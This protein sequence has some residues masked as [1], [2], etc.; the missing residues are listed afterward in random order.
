MAISREVGDR[1]GVALSD[2]DLGYLAGLAA[3]TERAICHLQ[4][5]IAAFE[6]LGD[7]WEIVRCLYFLASALTV[8][9]THDPT[10]TDGSAASQPRALGPIATLRDATRVGAA[11]RRLHEG[12]GIA[13]VPEMRD[14]YERNELLL[15]G[16]LGDATF[17][18]L[19]AEGRAM[20][21]QKTLAYI[22]S[23]LPAPNATPDAGLPVTDGQPFRPLPHVEL[24]SLSRREREIAGLVATGRTNRQIA[25]DLAL[26]S[27]TVETHVHNILGKLGLS[28]RA[29]IVIW[30]IEH[31]LAVTRPA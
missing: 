24:E 4:A 30:A 12:I 18:Q 23:I 14:I 25:D 6:D 22:R 20:S 21:L 27:R 10:V 13:D 15:R 26:S 3:D 31:G 8:Q 11:A 2:A 16:A 28:S 5:A 9:G 7:P 29:Q 17:S 1:R 19:E